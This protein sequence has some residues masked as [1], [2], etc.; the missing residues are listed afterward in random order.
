MLWTHPRHW[1]WTWLNLQVLLP[2]AG[3]IVLSLLIALA[4]I[5]LKPK[6]PL[7]PDV[8]VDVTPWALIFFTMALLGSGIHDYWSAVARPPAPGVVRPSMAVIISILVVA[9]AILIYVTLIVA[10]RLQQS[11]ASAYGTSVWVLTFILLG[12]SIVVCHEAA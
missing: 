5:T 11:G 8:I 9:A 1:K 2:L 12:A 10:D 3:P 6:V 7:N 4:L